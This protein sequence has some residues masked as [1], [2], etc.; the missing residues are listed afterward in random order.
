M[1]SSISFLQP[2]S[3]GNWMA[4]S[5]DSIAATGAIIPRRVLRACSRAAA[6]TAVLD[7]AASF[8][9]RSRGLRGFSPAA[10]GCAVN[11]A[12]QWLGGILHRQHQLGEAELILALAGGDLAELANIGAGDEGAAAADQHQRLYGVVGLRLFHCGQDALRNTGAQRV[13]RRVVDG[14]DADA[15]L[16]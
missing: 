1:N 7:R 15:G 4:F 12:D 5:T 3:K 6:K 9:L 8:S 14:D 2:W 16:I 10:D 11:R 13:H